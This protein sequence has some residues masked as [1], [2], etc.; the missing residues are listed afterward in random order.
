MATH[1]V[2]VT[3]ETST[4]VAEQALA[5]AKVALCRA[6]ED[7]RIALGEAPSDALPEHPVKWVQS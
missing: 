2:T 1:R 7:L 3:F 4:E 5:E 6:I